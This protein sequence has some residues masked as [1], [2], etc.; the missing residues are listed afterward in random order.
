MITDDPP[1]Q[2]GTHTHTP[3]AVTTVNMNISCICK[4]AAH[5]VVTAYH[6]K[7]CLHF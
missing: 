3:A 5:Y 7:L 4:T 2:T 6:Q 1:Q